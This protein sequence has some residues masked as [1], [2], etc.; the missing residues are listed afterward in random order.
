MFK[1][2]GEMKTMI[3]SIPIQILGYIHKK[4]LGLTRI[5]TKVK[6]M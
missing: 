5:S 4:V 1:T 2:S 6:S 3:T